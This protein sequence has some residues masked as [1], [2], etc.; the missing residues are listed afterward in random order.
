LLGVLLSLP[1]RPAGGETQPVTSE[2]V[3]TLPQA[4][5]LA[6]QQNPGM[7]AAAE[8]VQGARA[9]IGAARGA[10]LPQ[11]GLSVNGT[12][13]TPFGIPA[14]AAPAGAPADSSQFVN[15][16]FSRSSVSSYSA[17]VTMNQTLFSGFRLVDGLQVAQLG[18]SA[19]EEEA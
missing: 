13:T 14:A 1:V 4:L 19:S 2:D 7:R 15:P 17:Q 16:A 8:R 3:L 18:L 6:L 11:I 10:M 5:D 9:R 12:S